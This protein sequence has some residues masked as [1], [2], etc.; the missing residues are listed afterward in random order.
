[1]LCICQ[2]N[3]IC[4]LHS[5]KQIQ[6]QYGFSTKSIIWNAARNM[7]TFNTYEFSH[8]WPI[9]LQFPWSDPRLDVTAQRYTHD[10]IWHD[11][12]PHFRKMLKLLMFLRFN[13][14][15]WIHHHNSFKKGIVCPFCLPLPQNVSEIEFCEDGE[16][17]HNGFELME[18]H[19]T[20]KDSRNAHDVKSVTFLLIHT[21]LKFLIC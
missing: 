20:P 15:D 6:T 9:N 14:H 16:A 2:E 4:I 17:Q 10:I 11:I 19:T 21:V 5:S 12:T 3:G 13:E 8:C 18:L 7:M 1:M